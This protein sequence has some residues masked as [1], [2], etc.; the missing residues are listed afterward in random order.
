LYAHINN[1]RKMKKKK[2]LVHTQGSL[3]GVVLGWSLSWSAGNFV[4]GQGCYWNGSIFQEVKPEDKMATS[5]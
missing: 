4:K 1:K 3:M 5:L 2:K